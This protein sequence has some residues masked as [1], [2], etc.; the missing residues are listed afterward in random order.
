MKVFYRLLILCIVIMSSAY[1]PCC[2]QQRIPSI[3]I[4]AITASSCTIGITEINSG[5]LTSC[6][7]QVTLVSSPN[8]FFSTPQTLIATT[9][10]TLTAQSPRATFSWSTGMVARIDVMDMAPI[11]APF[12]CG[13]G[14]WTSQ[15]FISNSLSALQ[16][17]ITD[18]RAGA[19]PAEP[20]L[21]LQDSLT[22][23]ITSLATNN[24]PLRFTQ[25]IDSTVSVLA[26]QGFPIRDVWMR[27]LYIGFCQVELVRISNTYTRIRLQRPSEL[28]GN[29]LRQILSTTP[30]FFQ[31]RIYQAP[32]SSNLSTLGRTLFS[33]EFTRYYNFTNTTNNTTSVAGINQPERLQVQIAP[34]P[35]DGNATM[36]ITTASPLTTD[37]RLVNMLGQTVAVLAQGH[38]L[39]VG[40]N[41][42][43]VVSTG[44]ASGVYAVQ[45][46][47]GGRIL[48]TQSIVVAR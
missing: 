9:S 16:A 1:R 34:Q 43:P 11:I 6:T 2:A 12:R 18:S 33:D 8:D 45:I 21:D 28:F 42:F 26:R 38:R 36:S 31:L 4:F 30:A 15:Y 44:L 29:A 13:H 7:V 40:T 19:I 27:D 32:F 37:I 25:M 14:G 35:I 24:P 41:M 23:L 17:S 46:I 20:T 3:I 48:H 39:S 47:S 5:I 22:Y 10:A